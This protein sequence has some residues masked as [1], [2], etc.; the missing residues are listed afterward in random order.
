MKKIIAMLSV[1]LMVLVVCVGCSKNTSNHNETIDTKEN[2]TEKSNTSDKEEAE[3]EQEASNNQ[4]TTSEPAKKIDIRVAS[5]KGPTSLG[6]L[7]MM[8]E[9]DSNTLANNYKF[10]IYQ[11]ADEIVTKVVKGEVDIALIPANVASILYQKTSNQ[12]QVVDIN[13]LGVLY[14]VEHG[15]TI[16]SVADLANKTLCMTGK[17]TVPEFA[18][19]YLLSKNG[20]SMDD[21]NVEFKSEPAEVVAFLSTQE[22][23]IGILPQPFVA[24]AMM[25]DDSI[26]IALDLTQ[27]WNKVDTESNLITGVTI[28]R[29]EFLTENEEAVEQFIA[30]H[31]QSVDDANNNVED[32]AALAESF[33]IVKAAVAKVAIPY[34]NIVSITGDEMK[35]QLSGYLKTLYDANAE[36]VGGTLP[37]EG[38]YYTG[39]KQE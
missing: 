7:Q 20:L 14:V 22:D 36:S 1:A 35:K 31:A 19:S 18:L 5:L 25:Q 38:F 11:A 37:D 10:D 28:V 12:V 4:E 32:T 15:D 17:G 6:L 29:K 34:C 13:T 26:R 16:Q 24:S 9:A 27:E 39:S 30:E 33:D 8:S 2:Q 23:A 21:V 3:S